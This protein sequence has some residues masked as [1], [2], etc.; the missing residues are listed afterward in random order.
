MIVITTINGRDNERLVP[1][2]YIGIASPYMVMLG[3]S[4]SEHHEALARPWYITP[5][6]PTF[7]RSLTERAQCA[8][9]ELKLFQ[10]FSLSTHSQHV[11]RRRCC[12]CGRQWLRHVQ[13]R[14]RRRRCPSCRVPV[15]RRPSP[16]SGKFNALLGKATS[17]FMTYNHTTVETHG[18]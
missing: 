6:I 3:E 18:I 9:L 16:S 2:P 12:S 14:F 11:R 17:N 15:H 7:V 1:R 5:R 10:R 4:R 8:D 13:S